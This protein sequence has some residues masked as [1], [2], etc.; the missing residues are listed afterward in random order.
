MN[1]EKPKIG[2]IQKAVEKYNI[3]LKQSW[4]IGDTTVDIQTGINAGMKTILVLTGEAGN[5]GKYTV[6]PTYKKNNLL[7]A[8][9]Q[10]LD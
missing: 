2:M 9:S 10:I 5:D 8:V 7:D 3:D 1:V 4:Y 6:S